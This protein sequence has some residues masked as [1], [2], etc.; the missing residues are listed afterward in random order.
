MSRQMLFSK[1]TKIIAT[2]GP[3]SESV[4]VLKNMFLNGANIIRINASHRPSPETLQEAVD[5]IRS[6]AKSVDKHIGIMLD[7]QGP[8][9]RVGKISGGKIT[10]ETG[11]SIVL[12]TEKIEGTTERIPVSYTGLPQDVKPTEL[13]YLDDGKIQFQANFCSSCGN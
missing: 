4:E 10:L 5:L 1:R 12:T 13:L 8:K 7:L 6:T 9:I 3:A 2:L 11:A